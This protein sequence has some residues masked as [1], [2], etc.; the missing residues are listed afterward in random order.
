MP[1]TASTIVES[2]PMPDKK[3]H[4]ADL[5]TK[6]STAH[7]NSREGWRIYNRDDVTM[8]MNL[9]HA[10]MVLWAEELVRI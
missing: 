2:I 4:L 9:T 7:N 3:Q 10:H 1:T 6:Y 5:L 8:V